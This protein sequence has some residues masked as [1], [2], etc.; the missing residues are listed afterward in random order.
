MLE[1]EYDDPIYA[2]RYA[3]A[4]Q[5]EE[6]KRIRRLL[7]EE[8]EAERVSQREL[9]R[10]IGVNYRTLAYWVASARAEREHAQQE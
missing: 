9:A 5:E 8:V 10:R 2:I 4:R 6:A 1:T 7:L 3:L